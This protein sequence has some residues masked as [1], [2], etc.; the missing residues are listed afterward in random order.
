MI[1]V[2]CV[3]SYIIVT[4]KRKHDFLGSVI[5]S[6]YNS[7]LRKTNAFSPSCLFNQSV[8]DCRYPTLFAIHFKQFSDSPSVKRL[9]RFVP[10]PIVD[11]STNIRK[12][13]PLIRR[14]TRRRV[15][16]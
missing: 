2:R 14:P 7:S 5:I 8:S 9:T 4:Q 1:V 15:V 6:L 3:R 13:S 10:T 12:P 11:D 16:R